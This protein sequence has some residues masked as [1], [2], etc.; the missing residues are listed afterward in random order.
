MCFLQN[1]NTLS[2]SSGEIW[3]EIHLHKITEWSES[4]ETLKITQFQRPGQG[5]VRLPPS[6]YCFCCSCTGLKHTV[7]GL[8][9]GMCSSGHVKHSIPLCQGL[10]SCPKHHCC[11]GCP[12]RP[13]WGNSPH[14]PQPYTRSTLNWKGTGL[15]RPPQGQIVCHHLKWT[16]KE[17]NY[18]ESLY[19]FPSLALQDDKL[20]Q[21]SAKGGVSLTGNKKVFLVMAVVRF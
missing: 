1:G 12:E 5:Q 6:F 11:Q 13:W 16:S 18:S 7:W 20:R 4:E 15:A 14:H 19:V 10:W 2:G 21:R 9:W 3:H 17:N 8:F